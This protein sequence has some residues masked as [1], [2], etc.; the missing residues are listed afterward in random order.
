[1]T[2][3]SRGIGVAFI[4][5]AVSAAAGG[6]WLYHYA[7][8]WLYSPLVTLSSPVTYE[9]TR[10]ASLS[11]VLNDLSAHGLLQHPRALALWVRYL[12]SGFKLKAGEYQIDPGT[13]PAGLI[14]LF[15]SGRV[16]L[17]KITIVEGTTLLELRRTLA[18][19]PKLRSTLQQVSDAALLQTLDSKASHPEG[20]LFPDTYRFAK[21]TLDIDIMRMAYQRMQKELNRIWNDRDPDLPLHSPYDA[22]I[23]ASI[24]EKETALGS[25]RPMIA[26]VFVERLRRGMRLQTDPTVIYGMQASFDGD[27]RR[28]DL[29]RDTPYNTYTRIGLPPTPICFPS[30]A[31]MEAT[32]HPTQSNA[33][34]FVATGKSDGSHHFSHNLEEH[35]AAVQKYLQTLRRH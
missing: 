31:A 29:L 32:V 8:K 10:G 3:Q 1:M 20:L 5:L 27:L 13:S 7:K 15:G 14:E 4:L 23:L 19:E 35:N 12:R 33:L 26:G 34:F 25:E 18:A 16:L 21:G 17:H 9:V 2:R 24:V 22:L 28:A 30:E 6:F 11:A